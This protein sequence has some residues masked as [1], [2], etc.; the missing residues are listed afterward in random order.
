MIISLPT[1][2]DR[3]QH[4]LIV[5]NS[6]DEF[7]AR[8]DPRRRDAFWAS[9]D[10]YVKAMKDAS[11]FVGGA[12]LELPGSATTLRHRDGQRLVQDGPY[13]DSKEQLAGF[14]VIDVPDFASALDWARRF[15]PMP[16]RVL[17][18]RPNLRPRE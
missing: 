6:P 13:A 3:M 15:P 2:E 10:A 9:F 17:E 8:D 7:E 12:G 14:F 5:Y 16:D 11:I 18:V 4:T 1:P